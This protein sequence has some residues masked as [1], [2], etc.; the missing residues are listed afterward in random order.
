[1]AQPIVKA[2]PYASMTTSSSCPRMSIWAS[3]GGIAEEFTRARGNH[4]I[5]TR[6]QLRRFGFRQR[7]SQPFDGVR[8]VAQRFGCRVAGRADNGPN[9]IAGKRPDPVAFTD[10][11]DGH[12][13]IVAA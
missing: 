11:F 9:A 8:Q 1:M 3:I 13:F 12:V 2:A 4:F 7:T 6:P 5:R 10:Q